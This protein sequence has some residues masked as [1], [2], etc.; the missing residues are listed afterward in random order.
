MKT[1]KV[2]AANIIL[3]EYNRAMHVSEILSIAIE[4][5]LIT[6]N[7]KT[8]VSTL[9]ADLLKENMRRSSRGEKIRFE[10]VAPGTWQL[11]E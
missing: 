5:G 7:G 9:A 3:R 10:K 6:T 11:I 2:E 1:S 8:P 4:R